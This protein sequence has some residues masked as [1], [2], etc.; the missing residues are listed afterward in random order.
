MF[1]AGSIP[2]EQ[3]TSGGKARFGELELKGPS[4]PSRGIYA[5]P[6]RTADAERQAKL[7]AVVSSRGRDAKTL[8]VTY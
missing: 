5:G 6:S 4:R 7:A 3:R 8:S 1:V 2:L